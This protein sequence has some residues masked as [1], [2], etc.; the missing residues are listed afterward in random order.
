MGF[1]IAIDGPAGSGKSTIARK[2]AEILHFIYVDTGAMYRAVG[3]AC[4]RDGVDVSDE[5]AVSKAVKAYDVSIRYLEGEQ[6]VLLNGEDVS[7]F[8]RTEEVGALAS[9]VSRYR[10]VRAHLLGL[11]QKLAREADVLMDGRDIGTCVLPNADI[12]LFMTASAEVRA[13]RRYLEL[14]Q[15]GSTE[16]YESVLQKIIERDEQDTH[17]E[18]APLKAADDAVILDT[19]DM[20][21]EEVVDYLVGL[22]G[23]K[24]S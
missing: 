5:E 15:K 19:S 12:K 13:K 24:D 4:K 3:F 18:V 23:K 7:G 14:Q 1:N 21:V 10:E 20:S 22:A 17:R 6:R 11:Q 16:S 9:S 2:A 8:I